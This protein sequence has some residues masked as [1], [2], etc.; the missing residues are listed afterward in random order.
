MKTN[1]TYFTFVFGKLYE[2]NGKNPLVFY[3][4]EQIVQIEESYELKL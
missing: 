2:V 1:G 4:K 3:T